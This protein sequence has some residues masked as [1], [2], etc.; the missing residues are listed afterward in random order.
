MLVI[1]LCQSSI[2]IAL[3][4]SNKF[5]V[6]IGQKKWEHEMNAS[7]KNYGYG[8]FLS[9]FRNVGMAISEFQKDHLETENKLV[10][11]AELA[12]VEDH[13]ESIIHGCTLEFEFYKKT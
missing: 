8:D 13:A 6:I 9:S 5:S 4:L 3:K 2:E 11:A 1:G 10:K 7:M 12:I